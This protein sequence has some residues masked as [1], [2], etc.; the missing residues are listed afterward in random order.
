[1]LHQRI[2]IF[3]LVDPVDIV[4]RLRKLVAAHIVSA[5]P[6]HEWKKEGHKKD[7]HKKLDF[8]MSPNAQEFTLEFLNCITNNFSE[9]RIIGQSKYGA[10]YKVHI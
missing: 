10:V 1:M 5:G 8:R 7:E 9:D 3:G 2:T 6:A 4:A